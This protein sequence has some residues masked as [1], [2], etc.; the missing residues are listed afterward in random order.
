MRAYRG[1]NGNAPSNIID[2]CKY[3]ASTTDF[4]PAMGYLDSLD[5]MNS[6]KAS[7]RAQL[8]ILIENEMAAAPAQR[9][10]SKNHI[11]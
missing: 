5:Y 4:R 8:L 10:V 6:K 1:F 3:H 2:M 7:Q 11:V 9:E